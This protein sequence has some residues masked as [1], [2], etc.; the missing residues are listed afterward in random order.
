MEGESQI[1]GANESSETE[2]DPTHF[3][4]AAAQELDNALAIASDEGDH[5][6]D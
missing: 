1:G 5:A 6:E 4:E 2:G 3:G